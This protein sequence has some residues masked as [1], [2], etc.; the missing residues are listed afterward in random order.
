[1]R[2]ARTG[3]AVEPPIRVLVVE[4]ELLVAMDLE[5]TLQERG[6]AVVGPAATVA[7]ALRLVHDGVDVAVL[8]IN[9]EGE[10]TLSIAE[11]LQAQGAPFVFVTGYA[12][13]VLPDALQDTPRVIKPVNPAELFEVLER[14]TAAQKG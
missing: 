8:D 9:L 6:Y 7:E 14:V 2:I 12:D 4:D 1:M 10:D 3:E 13:R 5:M 11:A